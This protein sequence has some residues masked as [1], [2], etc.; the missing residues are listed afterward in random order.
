MAKKQ[1]VVSLE[2]LTTEFPWLA[3]L[4]TA[5]QKALYVSKTALLGARATSCG[6]FGCV[7]SER[8]T[9][10]TDEDGNEPLCAVHRSIAAALV[11]IEAT[12]PYDTKP[13]S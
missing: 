7:L 1:K 12:E 6:H 10:E 9:G 5:Q 2:S 8:W 13:K 3:A 11:A 4:L